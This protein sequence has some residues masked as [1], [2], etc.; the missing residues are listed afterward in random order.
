[1]KFRILLMTCFRGLIRNPMRAALTVLGIVI[2]IAA[3]VAIMEIGEGSKQQIADKFSNL[4]ADV[5]N[6][7]GASISTSGVNSGMGGK[8]SLFADD[9]R[10][11]MEECKDS[12]V[13]ASPF[14]RASGQVIVGNTNWSP[15]S[16]K[17]GNEYYLDI[18]GWEVESGTAFPQYP[19]R[20]L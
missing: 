15:G 10:A 2:G 1:M 19:R 7:F 5:V 6:I 9:A 20:V 16:I 12:V 17:G 13:C 8:A 3:V 18:E 4:G 11:I 14:V